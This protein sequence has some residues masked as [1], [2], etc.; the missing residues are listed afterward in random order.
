MR[1]PPAQTDRVPRTRTRRA[2]SSRRREDLPRRRLC[3]TER[4]RCAER[5]LPPPPGGVNG[6]NGACQFGSLRMRT[7]SGR[8]ERRR[9]RRFVHQPTANRVWTQEVEAAPGTRLPLA[10]VR[11]GRARSHSAAPHQIGVGSRHVLDGGL[12]RLDQRKL[13]VRRPGPSRRAVPR[14]SRPRSA[15]ELGQCARGARRWCRR[16]SRRPG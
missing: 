13:E 3:V 6:A 12:A 9:R 10:P 5:A 4:P 8:P 2:P 14:R 1:P 15:R 7:P 11:A 16:H